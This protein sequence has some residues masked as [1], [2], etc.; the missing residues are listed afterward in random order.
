M[1]DRFVV[2][3][4][5]GFESKILSKVYISY[6]KN[7]IYILLIWKSKNSICHRTRLDRDNNIGQTYWVFF[8]L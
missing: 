7:K 5:C 8:Y 1:I 4:V 3:S 2:L 6:D